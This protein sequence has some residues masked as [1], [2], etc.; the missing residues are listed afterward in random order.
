MVDY[1]IIFVDDP[2]Q[3]HIMSNGKPAVELSFR[4]ELDFGPNSDH[5]YSSPGSTALSN[6]TTISS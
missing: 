3:T 1:L 6:S 2:A 5:P 4:F